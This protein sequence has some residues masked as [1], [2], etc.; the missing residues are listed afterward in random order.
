MLCVHMSRLSCYTSS[1]PHKYVASLPPRGE[2]DEKKGSVH[3][4]GPYCE[5]KG[6]ALQHFGEYSDAVF[7]SS[8]VRKLYLSLHGFIFYKNITYTTMWHRV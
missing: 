1:T 6:S 5:K 2:A 7:E 3:N 4:K 8:Y